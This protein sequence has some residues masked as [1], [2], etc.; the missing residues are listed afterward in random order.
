M[1]SVGAEILGKVFGADAET[2][3]LADAVGNALELL[4]EAVPLLAGLA[5]TATVASG[6]NVIPHGLD[7]A[8]NGWIITYQ[9]A[10]IT[11]YEVSTD[12]KHLTLNSSGAG[13]I[14]LWVF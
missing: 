3:E 5:V 10:A 2:Q 6:N 11:L 9:S 1:S 4:K 14:R 8:T 12:A 13:D 7:H